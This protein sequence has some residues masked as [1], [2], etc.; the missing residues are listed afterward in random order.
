MSDDLKE[1]INKEKGEDKESDEFDKEL[2]EY[3]KIDWSSSPPPSAGSGEVQEDK[4]I[5]ETDKLLEEAKK[6]MK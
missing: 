6:I 2:D 5:L 1:L 3:L 4:E